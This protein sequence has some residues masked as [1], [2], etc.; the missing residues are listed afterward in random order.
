MDGHWQVNPD[1]PALLL[2]VPP[3]LQGEL[4]QGSTTKTKVKMMNTSE[5]R[6][7]RIVVASRSIITRGAGAGKYYKI[8][9]N[10]TYK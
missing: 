4:V 3:F 10:N 6:S 1:P 9:K 7:P 8:S 5:F 2:Q